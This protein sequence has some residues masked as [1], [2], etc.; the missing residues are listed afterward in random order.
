MVSVHF[1]EFPNLPF[2]TSFSDSTV[3]YSTTSTSLCIPQVL[4]SDGGAGESYDVDSVDYS[5]AHVGG[6]DYLRR[7]QQNVDFV[8]SFVQRKCNK[9][10][11][12]LH[13]RIKYAII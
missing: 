12:L 3:Q 7:V 9:I 13:F 6:F 5:L 1:F 4:T 10:K 8:V 2:V 11:I